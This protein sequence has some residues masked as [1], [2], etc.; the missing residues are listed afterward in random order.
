MDEKKRKLKYDLE[1]VLRWGIGSILWFASCIMVFIIGQRFWIMFNSYYGAIF[2]DDH[3]EMAFTERAFLYIIALI[4][5][6][7]CIYLF[8]KFIE[9]DRHEREIFLVEDHPYF[10]QP[11]H[12]R[13]ALLR[14]L[15]LFLIVSSI[16]LGAWL[17]TWLS[18]I[19]LAALAG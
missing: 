2:A 4:V 8:F 18:L 7:F 14:T 3:W 5:G 6:C 10:K 13:I 16:G 12:E 15:R 9:Q 19:V 1:T 11:F 17:I